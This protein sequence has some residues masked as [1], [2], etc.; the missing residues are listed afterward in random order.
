M[1]FYTGFASIVAQIPACILLLDFE[2]AY[3]SLDY[4]MLIALV[5][6]GIFFHGQTLVNYVLLDC[7]SPVTH[8]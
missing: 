7:I 5:L 1:Q 2:R 3:D 4:N 8:R 6:N